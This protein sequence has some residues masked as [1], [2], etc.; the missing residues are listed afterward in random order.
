MRATVVIPTLN[1]EEKLRACLE[2]L[3]RQTMEGFEVIVVDGGSTHGTVEVA[4]GFG[5]R[6]IP[7]GE[8][9]IAR[10][11]EV[12]FAAARTG[13]IA[14]TDADAVPP[15]HW[16]E[17]LVEPFSDPDVVGVYG[18]TSH[19]GIGDVGARIFRAWQRLHRLVGIPIFLG[20]NFAVRKTAFVAVGGFR[21]PDGSFPGGYPE[22]DDFL[23]GLKLCRVGKVVFL[24]YLRVPTSPRRLGPTRFPRELLAYAP[25]YFRLLY[26]HYRGRL[27]PGGHGAG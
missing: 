23:I 17:R 12:G 26:W 27:I 20:P 2:A 22:A 21:G 19:P 14:S 5:A 13:V 24:P 10:A 18:A 6:V 4:R 11:R 9:G 25:R 7:L 15:P 16:L 3:S 1:E 8:R